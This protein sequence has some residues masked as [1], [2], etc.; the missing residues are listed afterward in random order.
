MPMQHSIYLDSLICISFAQT[1]KNDDSISSGEAQQVWT[2]G[3]TWKSNSAIAKEHRKMEAV[4]RSV[5]PTNLRWGEENNSL[6]V[7]YAH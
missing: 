7:F 6:E 2:V 4:N 3:V 1:Y 5:K